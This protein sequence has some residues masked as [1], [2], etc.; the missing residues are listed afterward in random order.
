[1]DLPRLRQSSHAPTL[2]VVT[3]KPNGWSRGGDTA[4]YLNHQE[5][6]FLPHFIKVRRGAL[7][8]T[9]RSCGVGG[10]GAT[11][12]SISQS[13]R[14]GAMRRTTPFHWHCSTPFHWRLGTAR[15]VTR[16]E[17]GILSSYP[18]PA[19]RH[20]VLESSGRLHVRPT[21][22]PS[23][24]SISRGTQ[25]GLH[26]DWRARN[27]NTHG[28]GLQLYYMKCD[29]QCPSLFAHACSEQPSNRVRLLIQ[30]SRRRGKSI[31]DTCMAHGWGAEPSSTW[32]R[33]QKTRVLHPTTRTP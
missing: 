28:K 23:H 3:P 33:S 17:H 24:S 29:T 32:D 14:R 7:L 5:R 10:L 9:G 19:C 30:S 1:M 2:P 8:A 31:S 13:F 21:L 15:A 26:A 25:N 27:Q 12:T 6:P 11:F 18:E 4:I 22:L 16:P 20:P